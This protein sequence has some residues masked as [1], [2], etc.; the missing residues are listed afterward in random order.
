MDAMIYCKPVHT[1]WQSAFLHFGRHFMAT[2]LDSI[3]NSFLSSKI[4][5]D[6]EKK[7]KLLIFS[8]KL[9]AGSKGSTTNVGVNK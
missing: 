6:K 2:G 4:N 8:D 9:P 3:L 7:D 1:G 5:V